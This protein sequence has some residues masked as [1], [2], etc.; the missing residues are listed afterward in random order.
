MGRRIAGLAGAVCGLCLLVGCT[1]D[2]RGPVGQDGVYG[3]QPPQ[4]APAWPGMVAVE[5]ADQPSTWWPV[6]SA[7]DLE[8]TGMDG[9][10]SSEA[11]GGMAVDG[12]GV[13]WVDVP[14]GLVRLDPGRW[15]TTV[16][17]DSDD[18]ACAES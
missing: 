16:W 11:V 9:V 7:R 12:A 5:M 14:W 3:P 8:P 6:A 15:S 17:D 1:S 18:T 2:G 10:A 4:G 13:I